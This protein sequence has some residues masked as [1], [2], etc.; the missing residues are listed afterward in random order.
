M[1]PDIDYYNFN[2]LLETNYIV[3]FCKMQIIAVFKVID[4][5]Q[6][7]CCLTC[8]EVKSYLGSHLLTPVRDCIHSTLTGTLG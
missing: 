4:A 7:V 2:G 8:S 3:L 5:L 1:D 6:R